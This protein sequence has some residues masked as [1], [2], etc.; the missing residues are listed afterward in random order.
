MTSIAGLPDFLL[1]L[2]MAAL[3]TGLYL[4]VYTFATAHNELALIRRDVTAASVSLGGSLVGFALP[5]AVAIYNA[6]SVLDCL[7][8]GL[9]ALVVQVGIYWLVRL[10]LPDLSR[11]I[12]EDRMAAAVLLGAASLAGGV[13]NAA[14]MTY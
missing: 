6:R 11:R 1:Y 7:V 3:L 5:L 4:V 12:E 2:G 13:V 9:V 8:W 14:S 10:V